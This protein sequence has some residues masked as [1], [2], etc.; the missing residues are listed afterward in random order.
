MYETALGPFY[1]CKC[2]TIGGMERRELKRELKKGYGRGV[3]NFL[4]RSADV[5]FLWTS[6]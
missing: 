5:V 1:E 6:C 2:D 4:R 3:T